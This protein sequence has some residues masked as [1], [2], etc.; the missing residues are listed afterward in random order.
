METDLSLLD[1]ARRMDQ[2]ALVAIFDRYAV[3][4]YNYVL[5]MCSDPNKADNVVGEVFSI[6]LEQLSAGKNFQSNLRSHL[7]KMTYHLI[8]DESRLS[9]R[10]ASLELADFE[11]DNDNGH[12]SRMLRQENKMLL[13]TVI[14]AIKNHMTHDQ[15]HVIVLRYVEGFSLLETAEIIGKQANSVMA[16]QNRAIENVRKVLDQEARI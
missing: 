8:A 4:L 14:L 1:A 11:P 7:Y 12:H 2:K 9:R 6:F 13:D 3:E 15:R 16:I 5:R 10:E